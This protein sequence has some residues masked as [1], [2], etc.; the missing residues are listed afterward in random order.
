MRE[1]P[2]TEP[3]AEEQRQ[4][5]PL[6]D[7]LLAAVSAAYAGRFSEENLGRVR[8]R[9]RS[10]QEAALKLRQYPMSNADEP[11]FTFSAYRGED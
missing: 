9:I 6:T 7:G 1:R 10:A 11:D 5:P 4:E 2:A 3:P 8:E